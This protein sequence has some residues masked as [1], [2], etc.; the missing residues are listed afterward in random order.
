MY[1]YEPR[2]SLIVSISKKRE[3]AVAVS[4]SSTHKDNTFFSVF[5]IA[6]NVFC[7]S[8]VGEIARLGGSESTVCSP[9]YHAGACV[10]KEKPPRRLGGAAALVCVRQ[11]ST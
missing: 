4:L 5:Q 10:Y 1:I 6:V 9:K 8:V 7:K 11:I 3:T 2:K